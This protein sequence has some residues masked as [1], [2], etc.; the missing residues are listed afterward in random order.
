MHGSVKMRVLT[1]HVPKDSKKFKTSVHGVGDKIQSFSFTKIFPP[2]TSQKQFFDLTALKIVQDFIGGQNSLIFTYGVTSSGKTYT[3]QGSPGNEGVMPRAVDVVFNSIGEQLI[4]ES[5]LQLRM[6]NSVVVLSVKEKAEMMQH[7]N[8]ILA[9]ADIIQ[10]QNLPEELGMLSVKSSSM[11][12]SAE[13]AVASGDQQPPTQNCQ[14]RDDCKKN[15]SVALSLC[16][17]NVKTPYAEPSLFLFSYSLFVYSS[18]PL[19]WLMPQ[20]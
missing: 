10:D 14:V 8:K 6:A 1:L 12:R 15:R 3:I 18:L 17:T 9:L 11:H 16:E 5:N 4:K 20:M 7:K 2:D 13:E 19:F